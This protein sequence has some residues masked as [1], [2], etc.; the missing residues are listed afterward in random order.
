MPSLFGRRARRGQSDSALEFGPGRGVI[1]PAM[2]QEQPEGRSSLDTAHVLFMDVVSYSTLHSDK[3]EQLIRQLQEAVRGTSEFSRAQATGQLISLPTGDGMALVFFG[4]PEAPV[5]CAVELHE[6]LKTQPDISLRMGIH[7]GPVY[8]VEDINANRNVAGG[9]IN[10][11][12]RIMDCGD[13]GHILV[14]GSVADML[15]QVSRWANAIHDLGETEVKHGVRVRLFSFHGADIGNP[16]LPRKLALARAQKGNG[17]TRWHR[18]AV[19]LVILSLVGA[20][21]TGI[22]HFWTTSPGPIS[23]AVLPFQKLNESEQGEIDDLR[24]GIPSEIISQLAALKKMRVPSIRA[25]LANEG[26]GLSPEDMGRRLNTDYVLEGNINRTPQGFGIDVTLVRLK[27]QVSLWGTHYD[28]SE[29]ALVPLQH[30]I[31]RQVARELKIKMSTAEQ[32][33]VY[34]QYTNNEEAYL[35]YLKGRRLL[36]Q[37]TDEGLREAVEAF[38][39]ALE[40]DDNNALAH[41]G[42]AMASAEMPSRFA[43]PGEVKSW[44]DLA[45]E[46]ANRA[47]KIDPNLAEAHEA[48]AAV[49]RRS[50]YDWEQTI[51]EGRLALELSPSLDQ[52]HYYIAGAYYHLG[53]LDLVD[54]EVDAGL[55]A[56][57]Q[58]ET[59]EDRAEGE[60]TKG[61]AALLAGRFND[62]VLHLEEVQRISARPQSDLWL[63]RAYYHLGRHAASEKMLQDL[64]HSSSVST[65][66]RSRA[67]LAGFLA[68]SGNREGSEAL[69]REVEASGYMD[70]HVA[71]SLA[72]A[73]AQLGNKKEAVR[74]LRQAAETGFPCYPWYANNPLLDPLR[75]DPEF[76][77][78]L[79]NMRNQWETAKTRYAH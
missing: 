47:V 60:R 30:E 75:G 48:L 1:F 16:A 6:K 44:K 62:A 59:P 13:A 66:T 63:A 34:R 7:T 38:K 71:H 58:L 24:V 3:Q 43:K 23:L 51:R 46:E 28:A 2:T 39:G 37:H 18:V 21:A 15:G 54:K 55:Q 57:G 52:P 12:Q 50:E 49:A 76:Q 67:A 53:L 79:A 26:N 4:D 56:S 65:A 32:E 69:I 14:S 35:L 20:L 42:L 29:S 64:I 36:V 45:V 68:A 41:A 27:D 33:R 25:A 8:R 40:K 73:Y 19:A 70:H 5:R 31:A 11:A 10:I 61:V 74:W 72:D 9:G 78:F 17:S 77:E 22:Y